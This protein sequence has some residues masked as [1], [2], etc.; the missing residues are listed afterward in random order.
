V[1]DPTQA[2]L[3]SVDEVRA[4]ARRIDGVA[5]RTPLL[6]IADGGWLKAECLQPIGS[7]KIRGA[8]NAVA[9]LDASERAAGVVTHSSGN[10]AQG[11]ARAARL[12]GIRA[13]VVMPRDASPIKIAAV[14]ADGAEI[15]FVG[16]ADD[17]RVAR[18]DEIAQ[19]EGLALIPSY[20]DRR[21]VAGQGTLGLEV[22]EQLT[23]AGVDPVAS[24]TVLVEI[25]GGGLSSGVCVAIK[26]LRPDARVIGV[27]PELA[28]DAQESLREHRIVRWA[29]EL[30]GRTSADGMR[31]TALGRVTFAHLDRLL[32]GVV[33]VSED[34]IAQAML[35]AATAARLVVE[36]SGATALA[37]WLFHRAELPSADAT[38]IVVSGGNVDP[39][40][41]RELLAIGEEASRAS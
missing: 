24:L 11:V 25:G 22:I 3:V 30:T 8:F 41:Y 31:S 32:D 26:G 13:V 10:H 9:Q 21:I 7:F 23:A 20:D 19:R 34:E 14:R 33:T 35:H 28:A 1:A 36:P 18:A 4:A 29:P 12:L 5:I 38:A 27:E 16:P 2:S 39:G 6:A 15:D 37:A 40:R 17:E